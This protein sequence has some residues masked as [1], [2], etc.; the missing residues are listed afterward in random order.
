MTATPDTQSVIINKPSWHQAKRVTV[1]LE[2]G[3]SQGLTDDETVRRV[4]ALRYGDD[5]IILDF[6][7]RHIGDTVERVAH[8][9]LGDAP[10]GTVQTLCADCGLE[11]VR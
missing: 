10:A 8:G 9:Y 2:H 11:L 7:C 4:L 1:S 5:V 6:L 3:R